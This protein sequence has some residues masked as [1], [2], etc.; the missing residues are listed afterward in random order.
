MPDPKVTSK[1]SQVFTKIFSQLPDPRRTTKGNF[2]YPFEEILFLTISAVLSNA[3][4]WEQIRVFAEDQIG[5][6]RKFYPY[7]NG[8]PSADVLERLFARLD[9]DAFNLCFI[10]WI[11]DNTG[12]L[13][14][15]TISVDGKTARG[16][17]DKRSGISAMH[18]VSAFVASNRIT[19][20]QLAVAEKSNEIT[21]IPKLL[22]LLTVKGCVVTADAMG[23]QK[24]IADKVCEKKADYVLQVKGNQKSL[25]EEIEKVFKITK[26]AS[27]NHQGDFGRGRI[28]SRSCSVITDLSF[29][30][31]KVNWTGL[32]SIIRL[33][34]ETTQKQSLKQASQT[35]YFISSA[36][37]SATKFNDIIRQHWSIE[38]NLH[39]AL[40][41]LFKEDQSLKKKVNSAKNFDIITKM[42]LCMIEKEPSPKISR[43]S[44]MKKC[45]YNEAFREK[46]MGWKS[47][48]P[49]PI[50]LIIKNVLFISYFWCLF[51]LML[52]SFLNYF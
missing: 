38:N 7:E 25:L 5:W 17:S 23:C 22:D 10:E 42:A 30:D 15:E 24:E 39:W 49:E 44:K 50:L 11:N 16:S 52:L 46:V 48:I 14:G 51:N 31:E 1:K 27:S 40:D 29:L 35:S 9:T 13:C 43:V 2:L 47:G 45:A 36:K 32:K 28:E 19:L 6:L 37:F 8:T 20:G 12:V 34:R 21:A 26:I 33:E 4:S 41:V 3:K 18:M